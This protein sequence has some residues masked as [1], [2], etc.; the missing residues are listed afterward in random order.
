VNATE[1]RDIIK[2][3]LDAGQERI[4]SCLDKQ[5]KQTNDKHHFVYHF[6]R[7]HEPG[8]NTLNFP[9]CLDTFKSSYHLSTP[10]KTYRYMK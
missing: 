1:R 10:T 8:R 4:D 2:M 9:F 6:Y 7:Y 3:I 5:D